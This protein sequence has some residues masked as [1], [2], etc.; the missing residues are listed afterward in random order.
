MHLQEQIKSQTALDFLN[1]LAE[2]GVHP[3]WIKR[4]KCPGVETV[5]LDA[6]P[7][8]IPARVKN[9]LEMTYG[10]EFFRMPDGSPKEFFSREAEQINQGNP[11]QSYLAYLSQLINL[12]SEGANYQEKKKIMSAV[13]L[14]M[15]ELR[16]DL[17]NQGK[18]RYVLSRVRQ[19]L[20]GVLPSDPSNVGRE[21]V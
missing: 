4:V 11:P 9:M 3:D 14:L 18:L 21:R 19:T 5:L 8:F 17:F 2:A 10:P 20:A 13:N 12:I 16:R 6:V 1:S 15:D 7:I